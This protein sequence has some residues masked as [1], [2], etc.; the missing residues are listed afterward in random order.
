MMPLMCFQMDNLHKEEDIMK[1]YRM[2]I[3]DLK[4]GNM[5]INT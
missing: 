1:R 5:F 2:D 3:E 4:L